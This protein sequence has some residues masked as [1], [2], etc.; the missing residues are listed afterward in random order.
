MVRETGGYPNCLIAKFKGLRLCGADGSR[1]SVANTSQTK[2]S[3]L[4]ADARRHQAAFTPTVTSLTIQQLPQ[5][6]ELQNSNNSQITKAFTGTVGLNGK[7]LKDSFSWNAYYTHGEGSTR[8][9][10]VCP[11]SG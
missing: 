6:L 1:A 8:N 3:L 7:V 4:K 10:C 2:A 11:A 5:Q 9:D